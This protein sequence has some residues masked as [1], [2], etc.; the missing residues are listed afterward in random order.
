MG[1]LSAVLKKKSSLVKKKKMRRGLN[2]KTWGG[3]RTRERNGFPSKEQEKTIK[4]KDRIC[5][6]VEKY[7]VMFKTGGKRDRRGRSK[8]KNQRGRLIQGSNEKEKII[9][10]RKKREK[11]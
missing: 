1:A 11:S 6:Q 7:I 10:S 8:R 3:R 2:K 5:V 4:E 9:K